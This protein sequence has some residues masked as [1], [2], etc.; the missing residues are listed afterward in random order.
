MMEPR[1]RMAKDKVM[2]GMAQTQRGPQMG[3]GRAHP[4]PPTPPPAAPTAEAPVA[5]AQ[6]PPGDSPD[7]VRRSARQQVRDM[8]QQVD[9]VRQKAQEARC[10]ASCAFNRAPSR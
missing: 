2:Q 10:R 3:G 8:G 5:E 6:V 7:A 9:S 4:T 1:Q